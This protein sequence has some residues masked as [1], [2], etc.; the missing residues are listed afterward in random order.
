MNV[1]SFRTLLVVAAASGL[2]LAGRA[3]P[4][5]WKI[6]PVHSSV[7]FSVRHFVSKVPGTFAQFE[8]TFVFDQANPAA[9][10]AEATI[11]VGSVSTHNEKRDTH[12][13]SDDFFS[14]AKYPVIKFKS[15][16]WTKTGEDSYSIVG[17]LTIRDVTKEVTLAAKLLGIGPG[18]GGKTLSGWEA[19]TKVDRRDFGITYGPGV[20][21]ND[22][23]I[24]INVEAAK[25]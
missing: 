15:K 23:D 14:A 19:T 13:S 7:A 22:V 4:D 3:A 8:G 9:S 21:G 2:A 20:L 5:T 25:Q 24:T 17:D 1:R 11:Q 16:S 18:A 6:D 10:R 12:L